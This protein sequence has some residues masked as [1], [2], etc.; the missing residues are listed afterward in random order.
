MRLDA[1]DVHAVWLELGA[2][3]SGPLLQE[4]LAAGVGGQERGREEATERC[5]GENQTALALLHAGGNELRDPERSHAVDYNDVV[6]LLFGSLVERHGN[7]V[8]ETD[9]VHQDGDVEP[10]DELRELG[11]VGVLV[12]RKVHCQCLDRGLGSILGGDVGGE[13]IELRLSA[14]DEDQVVALGRK[15]ESELLAD[16]IRSTGN[17]GPRAAGSELRKLSRLVSMRCICLD[18]EGHIQTCRAGR[19]SS[20]GRGQC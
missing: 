2:K 1:L 8:A 12:L 7:V 3:S 13:G 5:H 16:A 15:R 6:H 18:N 9:V 19:T 4:G 14:R 20:A 10:V 17:K 11:V